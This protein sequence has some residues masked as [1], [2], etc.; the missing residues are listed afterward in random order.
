MSETT[1][2]HPAEALAED[3]VMRWR[4]GERPSV[5]EYTARYPELGDDLGDLLRTLMLLELSDHQTLPVRADEPALERLGDYRLIREIGRGGMGIVYEAEQESLCRRVAVKVLPAAA[6]LNTSARERFEREARAAA[7]LHHTNIVPVYGV[8][9][10][11]G[12]HYYA[13]Q[14]IDGCA[15]NVVLESMRSANL[16]EPAPATDETVRHVLS[17]WPGEGLTRYRHIA[18]VA[19]QIADALAYAHR[20]GV[21]HRDIKPANVLVG[22][23]GV[24]WLGDFGLAQ[25]AQDE[26]LTGTGDIAGTLRY[27]APERLAGAATPRSD[28]YALGLTLF[29]M[30]TGTPAYT[31]TDRVRLLWDVAHREVT[32]PRRLT[33]SVPIDLEKIILKSVTRHP[34]D[35]Y[36]SA[37]DLAADLRRF[38]ADRPVAARPPRWWERAF[39][40]IRRNPVLTASFGTTL[41]VFVM[42]LLLTGWQWQ[43]AQ[44]ERDK[45]FQLRVQADARLKW[46]QNL[47]AKV[48]EQLLDTPGADTFRQRVV[49][50]MVAEYLEHVAD[51]RT[52]PELYRS[53]IRLLHRQSHL[54][55]GR[56]ELEKA[57]L[58]LEKAAELLTD[59]ACPLPEVDRLRDG[60]TTQR[61]L[62]GVL[63]KR[64]QPTN[65]AEQAFTVLAD[66]MRELQ[67]DDLHVLMSTALF[68]RSACVRQID[69]RQWETAAA[70]C[71]VCQRFGVAW[72][73]KVA[74]RDNSWRFAAISFQGTCDD[75]WG[76]ICQ[77]RGDVAAARAAFEAALQ[78]LAPL[79]GMRYGDQ[80]RANTFVQYLS[81][82]PEAL[83][84]EG[85]ELAASQALELT[86]SLTRRF[87]EDQRYHLVLAETAY[88]RAVG[89]QSLAHIEKARAACA[90]GLAA[91]READTRFG[92]AFSGK[93]VL[94]RLEQVNRALAAPP[95]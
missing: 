41:A 29:E 78:R 70:T 55:H 50:S 45:Q 72:A 63:M 32:P 73:A 89:F 85:W 47:Q 95:P 92:L 60:M 33:P 49:D 51:A 68:L 17:T 42:G 19:L 93:D 2:R 40:W 11:Q 81:L 10:Q 24:A 43:V 9:Q 46:L 30:A 86:Q 48:N 61:E 27:L 83:G 65:A 66:R 71:A 37:D 7:K 3:F 57:Q 91:A 31:E 52:D 62:V 39:R 84:L 22:R 64:G 58:A 18:K 94:H 28:V 67:P 44:R 74:S 4:R 15:L 79:A 53:L 25:S 14:F 87:P 75:L 82:G 20:Q 59:P 80:D 88:Q 13:M 76:R 16:A 54:S 77:G 8:G 23:D 26:G 21:L 38:L 35:R 69:Q 5:S 36:P 12:L 1:T 90:L 56:N 34:G 6:L